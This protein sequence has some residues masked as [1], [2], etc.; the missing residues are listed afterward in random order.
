MINI[1][2]ISTIAMIFS[3]CSSSKINAQTAKEFN[4]SIPMKL[5]L[6]YIQKGTTLIATISKDKII[7]AADSRVEIIPG[8]FVSPR[9]YNDNINKIKSIGNIFYGIAGSTHFRNMSI[10]DVIH[11]IYNPKLNLKDNSE[12]ISDTITRLMQKYF[13]TLTLQEIEYFNEPNRLGIFS[14]ILVGFEDSMPSVSVIQI[15]QLKDKNG[16]YVRKEPILSHS[17][18]GDQNGLFSAGNQ[19]YMNQYLRNGFDAANMTPQ[20]LMYLISLEADHSHHVGRNVNYVVIL[21]NNIQWGKN[22]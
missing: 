7:F 6:Q 14:V 9:H 2:T 8:D 11:Q 17:F 12:V 13:S 21:P 5:N 10:E 16:F 4:E 18:T 20:D 15:T 22:Y 19:K 1:A 3:L